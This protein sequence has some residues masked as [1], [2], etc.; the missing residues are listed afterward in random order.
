MNRPL[1]LTDI[2]RPDLP[3]SAQSAVSYAREIKELVRLSE[4]LT[5]RIVRHREQ[6]KK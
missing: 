5:A 2:R 3:V 1:A 6:A 4:A